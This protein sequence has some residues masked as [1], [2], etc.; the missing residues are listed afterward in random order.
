MPPFC[1]CICKSRF[2]S[3]HNQHLL[4]CFKR[5]SFLGIC[6]AILTGC[7]HNIRG[8]FCILY[9]LLWVSVNDGLTFRICQ[10][11]LGSENRTASQDS[12]CQSL[13]LIGWF[14]SLEFFQITDYSGAPF[15]WHQFSGPE[16]V[17]WILT[18]IKWAVGAS[19]FQTAYIIMKCDV[20]LFKP[21]LEVW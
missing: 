9:G 12:R 8:A 5:S 15:N 3:E 18:F 21:K 11:Q 14:R 19:Q 6:R 1:A 13:P 17:F 7:E 4:K 16:L 10:K 2:F 20:Q